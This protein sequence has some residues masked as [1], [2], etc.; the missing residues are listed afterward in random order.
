MYCVRS[1]ALSQLHL[2]KILPSLKRLVLKHFEK[3]CANF[4]V[5]IQ[6]QT[7]AVVI[8]AQSLPSNALIGG[9]NPVESNLPN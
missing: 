3:N 9:G 2:N 7:F 5:K 1:N 6:N 4:R 8:P